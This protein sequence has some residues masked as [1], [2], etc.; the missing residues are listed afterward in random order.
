MALRSMPFWVQPLNMYMKCGC[1]ENALEVFEG[2]AER[3]VSSWN[4]L[5]LGDDE[6]TFMGV[7]GACRNMGSVDE[8]VDILILWSKDTK[9][10][11][12]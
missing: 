8:G 5:I 1:V 9:E 12:C 10:R 7:L 6:I 4:A 11:K 3:G 2:T